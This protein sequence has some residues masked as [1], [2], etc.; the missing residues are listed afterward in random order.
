MFIDSLML[1]LWGRVPVSFP[2]K[3]FAY[4]SLCVSVCVCV[5]A[6]LCRCMADVAH[7]FTWHCTTCKFHCITRHA[8][9]SMEAA[10]HVCQIPALI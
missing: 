10:A 1:Y 5:C 9:H 4:V 6:R 7:K 2:F 8:Q 3:M